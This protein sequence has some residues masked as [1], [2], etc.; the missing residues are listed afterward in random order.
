LLATA[1]FASL[2]GGVTPDFTI[3]ANF[4]NPAGATITYQGTVTTPATFGPS[5][6]PL[7]TD[8]VHSLSFP[9]VASQVNSPTN[10]AGQ[11]GQINLTP[12]PSPTGDYNGDKVVDAADYTV[13]RDTLGQSV[14]P[15]GS[16]ADGNANGMIDAGDYTFWL[17]NFG[18]TVPGAGK[19]AA[20]AAAKS[21]PELPTSWL[22]LIGLVTIG[23]RRLL[24]GA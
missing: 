10:F 1:G 3:P 18:N 13:W 16:G 17:N 12:P 9:V 21:A 15:N 11:T 14:S 7:P 8:G 5:S 4:F 20:A 24:S 19:G 23:G 2:A 6:T 22:L